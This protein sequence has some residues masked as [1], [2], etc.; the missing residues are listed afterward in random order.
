M[1]DFREPVQLGRTGLRV[2]RLGIGAS[3]GV[4]CK[5]LEA[6][7]ERG[8]NYFYWG[9]IRRAGM[10]D[11][12]RALAPRQRDRLV[13]AV[14]SF[15]RFGPLVKWSVGR[16]LRALRLDYADVLILGWHDRPPGAGV[17]DACA[18][19]KA[20]GRI[21]HVAVSCHHRPLFE[22][23]IKDPRFDVLMARY[24]AAHRGAEREIFPHL[25]PAGGPG[26]TT[27]TSTRWGYLVDPKKTPPGERVPRG[28]DCYRFALSAPHV[29]VALCGP[30]DAAEM[31]EA[32]AALDAGPMTEEELAW[33]RRVGDAVR[34]GTMSIFR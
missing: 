18:E 32:L 7:F 23:Y 6:A 11:A 4:S 12:V 14:Q 28:R 27:Y 9:S 2:G 33:M 29:H 25:P 10:R 31:D 1:A 21:R 22:T 17:L 20:A 24:N 34:G 16:A 26:V 8:A 13:V 5:S 3:Y 15:A 19:L 30:R